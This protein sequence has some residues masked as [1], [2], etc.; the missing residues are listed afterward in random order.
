MTSWIGI[1]G[2]ILMV[3]AGVVALGAF[4]MLS[5]QLGRAMLFAIRHVGRFVFGV[6]GDL[7]RM[8]GAALAFMVFGVLAL[9][10]VIIG[11]WPAANR[12]AEGVKREIVVFG[13]KGWSVLAERPLNVLFLGGLLEPFKTRG[14]SEG[15]ESAPSQ[16]QEKPQSTVEFPG[17]ELVGSLP[18]GGSGAKLYIARPDGNNRTRSGRLPEKVV[19][20]SFAL[21]E[22]SS[23][24]QIVRES[25]ALE[26]ARRLGLVLEHDLDETKFWYA[27]P[28]HDGDH[29]GI[30]VRQLHAAEMGN[31]LN[32]T[33]LQQ[34][35]GYEVDLLETLSRYHQD[36][37]WHKDVKPDNLIVE[38]DRAHLV[39]FGL[40]TSLGSA[41]TLTTHGTEYFRDPEM[42]RMALRGVKVHQVNGAKFDIYGAGA[43]LY[44]MLEN[45]FPAHGGLSRFEKES[46]EV[47]RWIVRRS[48]TDYESRYDSAEAML[49]D[50]RAVMASS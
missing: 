46:P 3:A 39:D 21:G 18:S 25:R 5:V 47:L 41:M 13:R 16:P 42:V 33:S 26:A 32:T 34:V 4:I 11:R 22:G 19:I 36:G 7:V 1:L 8:I 12:Y 29:L 20:K 37:L 2:I 28:Y 24:P 38:G 23:L 30:A 35:L 15:I 48:M 49:G 27:M 14:S 45:T 9:L 44:F 10:N 40:V 6:I 31:G 17:F 50:L 43:V